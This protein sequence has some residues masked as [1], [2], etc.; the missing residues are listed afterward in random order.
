[1]QLFHKIQ[2]TKTTLHTLPHPHAH[3][4]AQTQNTQSPPHTDPPTM[5]VDE[6]QHQVGS[7]IHCTMCG[8]VHKGEHG[9]GLHRSGHKFVHELAP[10]CS[11]APSDYTLKNQNNIVRMKQ[12]AV[13]EKGFGFVSK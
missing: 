6:N 5:Q 9:I 12:T 10:A 13:L 11:G 1:M 3:T 2:I 4:P 8:P 7:T